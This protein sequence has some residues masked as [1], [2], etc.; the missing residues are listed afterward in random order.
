MRPAIVLAL[1]SAVCAQRPTFLPAS[2]PTPLAYYHL[3]DGSG[4]HLRDA[5]TMNATAGAPHNEAHNWA[6]IMS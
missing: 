1:A 4:W 5:I 2:I 6:I 3:N